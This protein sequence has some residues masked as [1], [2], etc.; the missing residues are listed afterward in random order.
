M[1][2]NDMRKILIR[3]LG[4]GSIAKFVGVA[5]AILALAV[6][7]FTM[8]GGI[9]GVL[10]QD[11]WSFLT[12]IFATLGVVIGSLVILP[13]VAFIWGW[14]YGAV[15]ALVANLFLQTARG[16]ELDVEDEK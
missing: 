14:L 6:G 9:A 13:A 5:N 11:G 8:F 15:V 7:I 10:E 16:I 4:V 2:R 3:K 12:K 1:G